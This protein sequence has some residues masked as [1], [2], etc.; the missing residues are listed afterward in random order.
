MS[1]P[2]LLVYVW[3]RQGWWAP[4]EPGTCRHCPQDLTTCPVCEGDWRERRCTACG[5]GLVCPDHGRYWLV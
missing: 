2:N 5:G 1:R 4:G 3:T